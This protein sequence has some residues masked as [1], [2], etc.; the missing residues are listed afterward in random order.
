MSQWRL[1]ENLK[2]LLPEQA[3][4]LE[5]YRRSLLDL[6]DK[7]GYQMI[8]PS[9]LE[10][11][12]T[13]NAHGKDLDLDTYKVVDQLTGKMM[14]ISSDLTTQTA[15]I[16]DY[17]SK[18]QHIN[19]LCYAGPV[20]RT[21]S[22]RGQSRELYQVGLECF[23]D[24]KLSADIEVQKTLIESLK[25]LN[26]NDIVLDINHLDLYSL[27]ISRLG[28]NNQEESEIAQAIMIKDVSSLKKLLVQFK[29]NKDA[30]ML[31]NLLDMYGDKKVIKELEQFD[32]SD[33]DIQKIIADL[34]VL[35]E[36]LEG[37]D[38]KLSFDFSDIRGYQY[39]NGLIFS[40]YSKTFKSVIAQG[41]RYDNLNNNRPATGFSMDLSYIVSHL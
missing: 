36:N 31:L 26:L 20:L 18:D 27:I 7:K 4:K 10:Y 15:R 19:K 32:S 12:D 24:T 34:E 6:F 37:L 9:L 8:V 39:H 1:P 21:K 40:A 41:G 33:K 16:D 5:L 35:V 25:L 28:L 38:V 23:G 3:K 22:L 30:E 14:G 2:D 13:L 17:L 11:V 29:N